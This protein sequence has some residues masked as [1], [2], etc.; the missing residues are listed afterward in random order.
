MDCS[1][2]IL[3]DGQTPAARRKELRQGA[4]LV[5]DFATYPSLKA[6]TVFVTGGATGIG[7][8]FVEAFHG[9]GARVA[10]IDLDEMAGTALCDRLGG[11]CW[12][13]RCDVTDVA[14]LQAAIGDAAQALGPITILINNV[15]DDTR[16]DA[17]TVTPEAWRTGLAV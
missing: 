3:T 8:A 15:A 9:Q 17:A 2:R 5:S 16:E 1:R 12:F 7:A 14:A 6:R 4:A 11:A 13:G 10:F